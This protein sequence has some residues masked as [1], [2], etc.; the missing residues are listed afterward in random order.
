MIQKLIMKLFYPIRRKILIN[1]KTDRTFRGILWKTTGRY[2]V[3][4][5]AEVLLEKNQSRMTMDGE[6]VIERSNVDFIQVI[7]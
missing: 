6:V 5:N 4:K 2:L 7:G 1:T 3:L